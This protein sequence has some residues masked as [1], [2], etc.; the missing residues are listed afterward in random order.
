MGLAP[1]G[2]KPVL[3]AL[4]FGVLFLVFWVPAGVLFLAGTGL[5]AWFFRDPERKPPEDDRIWVSPADGKV[6]EV[7]RA[8]HP[9]CGECHYVGIFM[10]L[11]DVH[12]NRMPFDGRIEYLEYVPGKKWMAFAP[13]ASEENERFLV[14]FEGSSG[15]GMVVQ[16]AGFLARRIVCSKAR[17]DDLFR[18]E[19]LGMIKLGSRV[20]VYMPLAVEP[21]VRQG[22]RVKAG[23]TGIGVIENGT[24]KTQEETSL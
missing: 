16:I 22:Q 10:S 20:D 24:K 7:R 5:V 6:V 1:E 18:G 13:K 3:A 8:S 14:G 9:F 17:G 11:L 15:K 12:V 19:R 4:A 2:R 23:T 21:C